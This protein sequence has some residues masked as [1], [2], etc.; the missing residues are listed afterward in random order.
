MLLPVTLRLKASPMLVAALLVAH[1]LVFAG[2]L[3]TDIPL[4]LKG[5]S[6]FALALSLGRRAW[7]LPFLS[8]TLR[9]DGRL[10]VERRDG[11]LAEAQVDAQTTVF[12]WLVVL[13]MRLE[14]KSVAL[15]LAPDSMAD[16]DLR[17]LRL[18]LRWKA[19]TE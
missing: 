13:R 12:P 18:W 6:G 5:L 2:L 8:L 15:T 11:A 9:S 4:L 3:L 7:R 14:G 16:E 19:A 10:E 17:Q 1:G